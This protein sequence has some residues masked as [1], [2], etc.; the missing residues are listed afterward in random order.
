MLKSLKFVVGSVAKKDFVPALTHFVIENGLVRGFNGVMALS[1]PIPFDIACKPKATTL[2][3]AI[4]NCDDTVQLA[5]T[6]AGRLS[7][8]SGGFKAFVDCLQE[9]TPHAM[10]EGQ[11]V[12][13]NGQAL[14]AGLKAVAPFIGD[15][16][17]RRWANGVLV[18]KG[19]LFATNNVMLVQYWIGANFPCVVNIPRDAVREMLR[20]NEA[21]IFAQLAENSISFHYSGDRWLRTQLFDTTQWPDLG[22]ILDNPSQQSKIDPLMFKGLE[23]IK[24]FV[25]KLGTVIFHQQRIT[26]HDD[27][28]DGASYD[29]PDFIGEEG[30]YNIQ[31]LELLNGSAKTIDWGTYPKPCLFQG[32]RLRG[33][34]IGMKR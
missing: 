28:G 31:M 33:A 12:N 2:I 26:T 11:V 16:A 27:E 1:S 7:V 10:P 8:K 4:A 13:F 32:D 18:E 19:S 30:R 15:D 22:R 17:S 21:P 5:L 20:I 24:P 14:L 34:I 9:D 6:P 29:L 25:D 3:K 23:V